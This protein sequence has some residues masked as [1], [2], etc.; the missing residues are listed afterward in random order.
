MKITM[1]GTCCV[2]RELPHSTIQ[3]RAVN[4]CIQVLRKSSAQD[5]SLTG[6]GHL[7]SHCQRGSAR[8]PLDILKHILD[9]GNDFVPSKLR[10]VA[11]VELSSKPTSAEDQV[12]KPLPVLPR[13]T[14]RDR[15]FVGLDKGLI[16]SLILWLIIA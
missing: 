1:S 8:F 13:E 16:G 2:V 12:L 11:S 5:R 9:S 10:Q 7:L 4:L 14:L 15:I 3:R 6:F